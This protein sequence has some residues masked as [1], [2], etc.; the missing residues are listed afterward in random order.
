MDLKKT[1]KIAKRGIIVAKIVMIIAIP[2]LIV[3]ILVGALKIIFGFDVDGGG[4]GKAKMPAAAQEILQSAGVSTPTSST[5]TSASANT[6]IK[7]INSNEESGDG[8]SSITTVGDKQYRNYKQYEGSY[9]ENHY[10][11]GNIASDGC[12]PSSVAIVLSGYGLDYNPGDVVD[13]FHNNGHDESTSFSYLTEVLN[14]KGIST[15]EYYCSGG[16]SEDL[17]RIKKN[18]EQNRP[19]IVNAPGHYL[20]Y[21]GEDSDGNLIISDPGRADG[22]NERYG[23]TLNDLINNGGNGISCG[24]ILITSDKEDGTSTG[25]K[26]TGT[27]TGTKT[28]TTGTSTGTSTGTKTKASTSIS[29]H[30]KENGRGGYKADIDL[31]SEVKKLIE[32]F[33]EENVDVLK[34]HF[35]NENREKYLQA[36]LNAA[37]VTSYPDL[38]STSEIESGAK[39]PEGE[40]QGIIKVKRKT[41]DMDEGDSGKFL[42]YISYDK[43]KQMKDSQNNDIFNYFTIDSDGQILVAGYEKRTAQPQDVDNEQDPNPDEIEDLSLKSMYRITDAKI[44]YSGLVEKYS[45]PFDLLWSLLVYTGDE[46]FVYELSEIVAKGEIIIT[47]CDNIT[48]KDV[49]DVY[50]Y[51]KNVKSKETVTFTDT[52]ENPGRLE[53]QYTGNRPDEKYKYTQTNKYIYETNTPSMA[54][55]YADSWTMKYEAKVEKSTSNKTD[56]SKTNEDDDKNYTDNG[57]KTENASNSDPVYN[58]FRIDFEKKLE[59]EYNKPESN[60]ESS[61]QQATNSSSSGNEN[62]NTT[63]K[64]T[65]YKVSPVKIEYK[66]KRTKKE[67]EVTTNTTETKF[68]VKTGTTTEKTDIDGNEDNFVKLLR[69]HSD[70]RY[71]LKIYKSWFF[72]SVEKLETICDMEDMLKYLLQ[73]ALEINL[74]VDSFDFEEYGKN[75]M[76]N[77]EGLSG[78]ALIQWI[79][80]WENQNLYDFMYGDGEYNALYVNTHVTEDKKYYKARPDSGDT[81]EH[82]RNF[83][84]GVCYY[85]GGNW[86]NVESFRKYGINIQDDKYQVEEALLEC[87]IVD[88][89]RDDEI[90]LAIEDI[91][92]RAKREGVTLDD[93]Q[94]AVLI[95]IKY[96]WGNIGNFFD[97]YKRVGQNRKNEEIRQMQ[98]YNSSGVLS[99]HPLDGVEYENR[100]N[101]RWKLFSEGICIA[102][103]GKEINLSASESYTGETSYET[104]LSGEKGYT[105]IVKESKSG[106]SYKVYAQSK[107]SGNIPQAGCS[108]SS[109]AIVLSG[110][111]PDLNYTPEDTARLC[112]YNFPRSLAQIASD[113]TRL[114]VPSTAYSINPAV[115][116]EISDDIKQEAI[117]NISNNLR[118]GKPVIILVTDNRTFGTK[119]T[120]CAHYMALIGFNSHGKPVIADPARGGKV[121][122]ED[123]LEDIVKY[124]IYEPTTSGAER[125]YV[126]IN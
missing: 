8:Y 62:T 65:T 3:A 110:Y 81:F 124:N 45:M 102:S 47:V 84:F 92:N 31:E 112:G 24:Y 94:I 16:S 88:K 67:R 76:N 117:R 71:M 105:N 116:Q 17:E 55:T 10:W 58:N 13:M 90:N 2:F 77:V 34:R 37:L 36:F 48:T 69:K 125:G 40:V 103:T 98:C 26:T 60:N 64:E 42:Q 14:Q 89:V 101:S 119:Y 5:S 53:K 118:Q 1:V 33:E 95:D 61:N 93:A 54:V 21:L 41:T 106:K 122:E 63:K 59:E 68:V 12:G 78:N 43:Y 18:F 51:L 46:D 57:V 11:D 87:E 85:S 50:T 20:A 70:A 23:K 91:K 75:R 79:C 114:K 7:K 126:L 66:V 56:V 28:K 72:D 107:F 30:I 49:T 113:L 4:K 82:N 100:E 9:S 74:G 123:T 35:K 86:A 6:E 120:N 121:W 104:S 111:R 39:I 44:N 38:R 29:G 80:S 108:I 22:W 32:K 15:E 19:I 73:K 25:T 27:S 97:V 83:G 115:D 96:Q 52:T 99:G 109:E